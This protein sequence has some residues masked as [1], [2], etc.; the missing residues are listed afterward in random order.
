MAF[1]TLYIKSNAATPANVLIPDM[2]I[3]VLSGSGI[4]TV[5]TQRELQLA[6]ESLDLQE[7]LVD[8]AYGANSSTLILNNGTSDVD[9]DQAL[10]YL[11]N[12]NATTVNNW[13]GGW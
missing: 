11:Q 12:F 2:G 8:D 13:F 7:F 1:R 3:L 4:H 5:D 6:K 10:D 9:Q